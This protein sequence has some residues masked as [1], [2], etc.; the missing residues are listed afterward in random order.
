MYENGIFSGINKIIVLDGTDQIVI[1]SSDANFVKVSPTQIT[2]RTGRTTVYRLNLYKITGYCD[3]YAPV[4]VSGDSN[5]VAA[6]IKSGISIFGVTGT[7]SGS[8]GSV[9]LQSKTGITPT[10]SSQTITADSGY[11]GLSSV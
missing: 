1:G 4:T 11:D 6:N 3:G 8:S 5:L 7:Y 9:S 10:E 2:I